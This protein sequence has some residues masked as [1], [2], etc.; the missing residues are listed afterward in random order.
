MRL[1][2]RE[3]AEL[4]ER[5]MLGLAISLEAEGARIYNDLAEKVRDRFPKIASI[6][7]SM[8]ADEASHHDRL[9]SLYLTRFGSHIPYLRRQ[10]V[11]GF[12]RRKPL[13]L[14]PAISPRQILS[15]A[16]ATEAETRRY[17]QDAANHASSEEVRVLLAELAEAEEDHVD[18]LVAEVKA[19]KK[20]HDTLHGSAE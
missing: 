8:R 7:E 13:W 15:Y 10:D 16:F 14:Q 18:L 17:Y 1:M 6:L 3:I 20:P 19:S 12:M 11:K 2:R 4:S 5:E 9:Q